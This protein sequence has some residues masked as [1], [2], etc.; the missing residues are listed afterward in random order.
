MHMHRVQHDM[1]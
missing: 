1:G